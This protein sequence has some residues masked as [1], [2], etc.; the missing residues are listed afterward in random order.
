MKVKRI[1]YWVSTGLLSLLLINA[2]Y[3]YISKFEMVQ[4]MLASYNY[5]EYL[6]YILI[7]GKVLGV[8]AILSNIKGTIK[9]WAYAG[10]FFNFVL[11]FI[12]HYVLGDG[13]GV[14]AII[15]LVLLMASYFLGRQVR[16]WIIKN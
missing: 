12:T 16:P 7:T 9:E 14:G 10:L 2:I 13:E 1:L 11:A 8:I 6:I 4:G 3:M 15:A 5:P